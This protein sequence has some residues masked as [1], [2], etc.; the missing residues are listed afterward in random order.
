M[1]GIEEAL[2]DPADPGSPLGHPE[3]LAADERQE[4][5]A[6]GERALDAYGL[7]AEFVPVEWGGRLTRLDRM[8]EV[9][10]AVWRRDPCLGLGYGASSFI[11]SVNVWA[12]GTPEQR[13]TVADTLLSGGKIASVYHELAHGNDFARA[14]CAGRVG[15][16]GSVVLRGRK[17]V[18]TNVQRADALVIFTRTAAD[19]GS[20]SHSQVLLDKA[21]VPAERMTYLPRFPST[22]MRGVQLGGVEFDDCPTGAGAL[23]GEEG[24]GMETA[25]RSFQLTRTALPGMVTGVLD[26]GLRTV[27]GFAAGRR[28]YGASA[29]D[30]P[31][32][33]A[34]LAEGFADLL[35]CDAFATTGARAL[36]LMPDRSYVYASLVKYEVSKRLIDAMDRLSLILGARGYLR[37]GPH[38]IF[39]KLL[40]DL[41]V[42]GFGHAARVACLATVLPQLPRLARRSWT[43][44]PDPTAALS[45]LGGA[46]PPLPFTRLSMTVTGHDELSA[47]PFAVLDEITPGATGDLGE[48]RRLALLFAG[49]LKELKQR[50]A[51]L[52][53]RELGIDASA[54]TLAY[55]ARYAAVL[56]AASCLH[57]WRHNQHG[58]GFLADPVWLVAALTRLAAKTGRHAGLLPE[59]VSHRLSGELLARHGENRSFHL[60][61]HPLPR[62]AAQ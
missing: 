11:S 8:I 10:R 25:L 38:A 20:R 17:E 3:V 60:S 58:G 6:E 21:D 23:I 9:M 56:G 42:V 24:A 45:T 44:A 47:V 30:I 7:N 50:C 19:A 40:R 48:V 28:L 53:P 2:G 61:D 36:H 41:A 18:V 22:G 62:A 35:V 57:V 31:R 39:Q 16:D 4:M 52:P 33:R 55:A 26:T 59:A 14:E 1:T 43:E 54:G 49:E 13:R 32:V 12:A 29:L 27:T 34:A 51:A 5:F 46:L 37:E 15:Q